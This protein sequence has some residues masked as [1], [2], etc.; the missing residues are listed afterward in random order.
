MSVEQTNCCGLYELYDLHNFDTAK[1]VILSLKSDILMENWRAD[2][3]EKYPP[4]IIFSDSK[5][6]SYKLGKTTR[7]EKLAKYITKCNLGTVAKTLY[8]KNPNSDNML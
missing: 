2:C 3:V 6:S 5:R 4:V 8:R 1:E 7:G